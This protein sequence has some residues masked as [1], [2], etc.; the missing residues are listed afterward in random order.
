[1]NSI[2]KTV[3]LAIMAVGLAAALPVFAQS[4]TEQ[5]PQAETP[6]MK[7]GEMEGMMGGGEMS[8]MMNM[9]TQMNE[10]MGACTKMMQA[11]IPDAATPDESEAPKNPG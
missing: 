2:S 3:G 6:A 11:M 5:T 10:M 4:E 9:M 7:P 1:M 8:G